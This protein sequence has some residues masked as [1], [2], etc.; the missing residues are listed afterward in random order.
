MM[1][2]VA[3]LPCPNDCVGVT[4]SEARMPCSASSSGLTISVELYL[5]LAG[6]PSNV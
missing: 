3:L 6:T 1:T 2:K 4:V 5:T